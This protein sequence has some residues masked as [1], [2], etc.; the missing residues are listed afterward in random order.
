MLETPLE[1]R[2]HIQFPLCGEKDGDS[3]CAPAYSSTASPHRSLN[4][5]TLKA[6]LSQAVWQQIEA[7]ADHHR[8][9]KSP[10]EPLPSITV[11]WVFLCANDGGC[12]WLGPAD[13]RFVTQTGAQGCFSSQP[14]GH[15][16][17]LPS[18]ERRSKYDG[19]DDN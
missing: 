7:R 14:S 18:L 9:W 6:D 1:L 19:D 4:L 8:Q 16:N 12:G 5:R 13:A 2:I 10:R 11:V 15:L 17:R 3:L